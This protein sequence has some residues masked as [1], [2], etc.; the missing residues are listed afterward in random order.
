[1]LVLRLISPAVGLKSVRN[2]C[3]RELFYDFFWGGG[4]LFRFRNFL[5]E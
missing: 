5:L 2:R 3:V 1:M 4:L